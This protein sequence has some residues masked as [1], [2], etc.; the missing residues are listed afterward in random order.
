MPFR[1]LRAHDRLRE[2]GAWR[3]SALSCDLRTDVCCTSPTTPQIPR[4]PVPFRNLR[5]N[6]RLRERGA[7]R[8][9]LPRMP[10]E[11]PFPPQRLVQSYNLRTNA[12][13]REWAARLKDACV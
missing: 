11:T 3:H 2:R 10:P 7:W 4:S 8:L 5:A 9:G 1:N 12:C 6:D 13:L